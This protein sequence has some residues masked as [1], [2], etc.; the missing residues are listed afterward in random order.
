MRTTKPTSLKRKVILAAATGLMAVGAATPAIA[1]PAG[2]GDWYYGVSLCCN[3][4]RYYHNGVN[5]GA[6]VRNADG[7]VRSACMAPGLV[8]EARQARRPS[9]NEAF[10]RHC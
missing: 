9:G 6:S 4:S 8:A 1:V 5:H 10:W 3:W 2:G 7:L